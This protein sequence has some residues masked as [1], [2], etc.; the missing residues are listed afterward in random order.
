MFTGII[1]QKGTFRGFRKGRSEML[2][3][4]PGF[5]ANLA[6]GESVAVNG[7]CLSLLASDREGLHF[8]LSRETLEKTTLGALK[9][10]DRLNLELPL[11]LA[12]PLS[13]HLV[14]GHI[15]AVGKVLKVS[16]R[17]PGKRVTL[18]FP[19]ALRPYFIPKGSVAVDGVSLT[20][21]SLGPASLEVELIPLSLEGSNLGLLRGGAAVNLECDMIGKYV[22]NWLSQGRKTG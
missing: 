22:Y 19:P 18:S 12:S 14:S 6:A 10:G 11:T 17:P 3:E 9:P 20:I 7:V 16:A 5:A 13:G 8:N 15:D 2:V 1:I 4:A 21:A